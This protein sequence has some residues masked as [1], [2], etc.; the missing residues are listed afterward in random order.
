MG[1]FS[2]KTQDTKR[3]IPCEG[4][5]REPFKVYMFDNKGNKFEESEYDG[6]GEFE[7]KDYYEL[8]AE[9]NG[10]GHDRYSGL[11]LAFS[12]EPYITPN[13]AEDPNWVWRNEKPDDC[14]YQGYFYDDDED[15]DD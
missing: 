9:M 7:G 8:L 13:L 3:S 14:E 12:K 6:Y 11:D 5:S 10:V 1:L 2:W 15:T 4:S